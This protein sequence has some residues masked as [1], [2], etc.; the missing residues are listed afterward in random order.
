MVGEVWYTVGGVVPV[1]QAP[2]TSVALVAV[3]EAFV[4]PFFPW[5][6]QVAIEPSVTAKVDEIGSA[7]PNNTQ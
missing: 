3:Q 5:Q 6:V 1:P 7:V 4:P 2:L